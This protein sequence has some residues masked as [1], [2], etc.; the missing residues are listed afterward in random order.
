MGGGE[1]IGECRRSR[2]PQ[3]RQVVSSLSCVLS[4]QHTLSREV[5]FPSRQLCC[6]HLLVKL[7]VTGPCNSLLPLWATRG[8]IALLASGIQFSATH[9]F[10]F[11]YLWKIKAESLPGTLVTTCHAP[12]CFHLFFVVYFSRHSITLFL[13][14]MS[15]E[16]AFDLLDKTGLCKYCYELCSLMGTSSTVG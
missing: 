7:P 12:Y 4:T 5:P 6:F 14:R 8:C 9:L 1:E 15:V 3:L 13:I 2:R 16:N 11:M 10:N